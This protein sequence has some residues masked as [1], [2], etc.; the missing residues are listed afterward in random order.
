MIL[1]LFLWLLFGH[2]F[3]GV[4][5]AIQYM[6]ITVCVHYINLYRY[7]SLCTLHEAIQVSQCTHS[8]VWSLSVQLLFTQLLFYMYIHVYMYI[9]LYH[10]YMQTACDDILQGRYKKKFEFKIDKCICTIFFVYC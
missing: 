8:G 5:K 7:H 10:L 2:V 4:H 3:V 1:F 9:P 6:C